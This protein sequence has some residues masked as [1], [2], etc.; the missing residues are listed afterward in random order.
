MAFSQSLACAPVN[1]WMNR[2]G[3]AT[4]GLWEIASSPKRSE[5]SPFRFTRQQN[6]LKGSTS[7]KRSQERS[8]S[9]SSVGDCHPTLRSRRRSC[10]GTHIRQC[11]GWVSGASRA[12][13]LSSR[14]IIRETKTLLAFLE[15][16]LRWPVR[17]G[18]MLNPAIA[19]GLP[20]ISHESNVMF[21]ECP[22]WSGESPRFVFAN[23]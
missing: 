9:Q 10:F 8:G 12:V 23:P 13:M 14:C 1:R 11:W 7:L 15:L 2:R 21:L 4:M 20:F 22:D 16:R 17:G 5:F 6:C 18:A 3:S 19:L